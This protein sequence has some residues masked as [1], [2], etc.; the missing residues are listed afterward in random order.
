MIHNLTPS[1]YKL[2][3]TLGKNR[4]IYY[5]DY[6]VILLNVPCILNLHKL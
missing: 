4:C 6:L 5:L 3:N 1:S 2:Q